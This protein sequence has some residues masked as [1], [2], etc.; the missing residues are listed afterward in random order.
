MADAL[1]EDAFLSQIYDAWHP[2][3]VR[4]DYDFYLPYILGASA[5]LDAGC[6]TG[7]LLA[8]A[9]RNGHPGRLCGLDPAS[10]M[11]ATARRHGSIEWVQGELRA[12]PWTCAFDLVVMTG[13]AFQAIL[14]NDDLIASARAVARALVPGGRFAFETR[15]PAARAW[16]RWRPDNARTV[17]CSDGTEVRITT[18][19]DRP[20]DGRTVAFTHRFEGS[21]PSLPRQS[22][23]TLRFLDAAS[24]RRLLE[25]AGLRVE[26]QFGHFAGGPLSPSAEE[27]ITIARA[28]D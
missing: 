27:I 1:F 22:S 26:S 2:R 21:H 13:H 23:S 8:E 17:I 20:F 7:T 16:E 25:G 24:V 3:T 18:T 10:G 6:G 19:L 15:N 12:A 28:K 5:V 14:T 11:I 4:D 9:R